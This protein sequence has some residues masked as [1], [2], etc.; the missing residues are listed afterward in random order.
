MPPAGSASA[1]VD[2]GPVP[3]R[4][5]TDL[6]PEGLIFRRHAAYSQNLSWVQIGS[7]LEN[8]NIEPGL[9]DRLQ[10]VRW[11]RV[12]TI[13]SGMLSLVVT[14]PFFLLREPKN[15]LVQS[16]KCAPVGIIALLGSV[17]LT[18][19]PVP[20]LPPG[21]AAM[22]PVLILLPISVASVGW[23]RT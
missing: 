15:M 17:I 2:P 6:G 3:T 9:H 7:M 12:A 5:V 11:G 21:F 8:T 20:G 14:I 22:L 13:V 19:T 16:L 18:A 10:R 23:V 4:I 1:V